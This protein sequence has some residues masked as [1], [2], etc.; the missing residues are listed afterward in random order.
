[1]KMNNCSNRYIFLF[2]FITSS[3]FLLQGQDYKHID[4]GR[5]DTY[6]KWMADKT[7]NCLT[8][9]CAKDLKKRNFTIKPILSDSLINELETFSKFYKDSSA[10]HK[11]YNA[12]FDLE[13]IPNLIFTRTIY[14]TKRNTLLLQLEIKFE[15]V[16]GLLRLS[17]I[18][19]NKGNKI[20]HHA[21]YDEYKITAAYTE[22]DRKNGLP[23]PPPPPPKRIEM[24][25]FKDLVDYPV[26]CLCEN[27][28]IFIFEKDKYV[29][30]DRYVY[31]Y[32]K[33]IK[34]GLFIARKGEL[35]GIINEAN[36]VVVPFEYQELTFV[37][38]GILKAKKEGHYGMIDFEG[39]EIIPF[40]YDDL[41][42][43]EYYDRNLKESVR[44]TRI[45]K[46]S[47]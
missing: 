30:N 2:V 4:A 5:G 38:Y 36:S 42:S 45:K 28:E 6:E 1:M 26:L 17:E 32:L 35:H 21:L 29:L 41:N 31:E 15:Y 10:H 25:V 40:V 13:D 43:F 12:F 7:L 18:S 47:L 8:Y 19:V 39:S 14:S 22:E 44:F 46:N 37:A 33:K 27:D 24:Y 3:S 16:A 23:P 20:Q 11:Y 34:E 9:S